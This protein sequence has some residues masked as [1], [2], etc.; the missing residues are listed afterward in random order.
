MKRAVIIMA[1]VP[2]AGNVKT[3]LQPFLTPEQSAD[4]AECL[5][6]DT[7]EKVKNLQNQLI[8]AYSPLKERKFFDKFSLVETLF[9]EQ[10]GINLG[11]KMFNAFEFA[12]GRN[13][14]SAV[15]I[16]T[17]S[18]TF[19]V[20]FIERAFAHLEKSDAVLGKTSD[21]GFYLIGLRR[22]KM[23]I[24]ENVEWSSPQTFEQTKENIRRAGL[25]LKETPEWF[26]VDEPADLEKLREDF[27]QNQDLRLIAP[28]TFEWMRSNL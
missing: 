18:P 21:G 17:D 9:V 3:R 19:P 2:R 14:D 27:A 1:K 15:M 5:M 23:E 11:E 22:L 10:K 20:E 16:G 4:F 24:F 26:D 25:K 6:R 13:A 28:Q 8:I 7:I 12:F